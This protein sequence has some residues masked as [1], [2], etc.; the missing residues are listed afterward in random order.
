MAAIVLDEQVHPSLSQASVL[1][2]HGV[3]VPLAECW[4]HQTAVLAF[5]RHFG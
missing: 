5:L 1:D 4:R 3:S 2:E